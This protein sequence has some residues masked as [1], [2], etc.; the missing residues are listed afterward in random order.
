MDRPVNFVGISKVRMRKFVD[1]DLAAVRNLICETID[2]SYSGAYSPKAVSF[3]K[4]YHQE[5]NILDDSRKG[6]T[7][8]T[9]S[10]DRILATGTLLG[11]EIKRV[12]VIPVMQGHGLGRDIVALLLQRARDNGLEKTFLDSS[13]VSIGFYKNLGYRPVNEDFIL[14]DDGSHLDYTRMILV[15][16]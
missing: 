6:H 9:E 10:G 12:F 5:S 8:V 11:N 1:D 3:F 2:F 14:L 4:S 7:I 16:E 13:V 15:L